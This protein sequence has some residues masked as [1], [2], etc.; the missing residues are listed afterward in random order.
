MESV[1]R[2]DSIWLRRRTAGQAVVVHRTPCRTRTTT[3]LYD[4]FVVYQGFEFVVYQGFGFGNLTISN[5]MP[6]EAMPCILTGYYSP[7]M[8]YC[9]VRSYTCLACHKS[10]AGC[11]L[12]LFSPGQSRAILVTPIA[13]TG[14]PLDI[15]LIPHYWDKSLNP[16]P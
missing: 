15:S 9:K 3:R 7:L 14:V 1:R 12:T 2:Q 11:N 10:W 5:N 13:P 6:C 8:Q 16:K 4:S